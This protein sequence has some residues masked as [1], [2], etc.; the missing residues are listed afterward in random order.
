MPAHIVVDENIPLA[1]EAFG[2]FGTVELVAGR[3]ID[4]RTVAAAD[5][6]IVRSVTRVNDALLDG[7]RV[8]F[9]G[10]ATIGTDHVDRGALERRGIAFAYAPGCNARSVA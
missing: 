6:L 1:H 10:T 2:P 7:S 4:A 3:K 8:R 5:A 9:V